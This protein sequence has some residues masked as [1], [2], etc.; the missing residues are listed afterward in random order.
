MDSRLNEMFKNLAILVSNSSGGNQN[1]DATK[2]FGNRL[3]QTIFGGSKKW[4]NS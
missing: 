3:K 4:L 2:S 1:Q